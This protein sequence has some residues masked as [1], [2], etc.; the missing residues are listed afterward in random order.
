MTIEQMHWAIREGVQNMD[1]FTYDNY[2]PQQLDFLINQKIGVFVRQEYFKNVN[3]T[4]K[5]M[6]FTKESLHNLQT[7]IN[8]N[9]KAAPIL[10][11][12][13]YSFN[14]ISGNTALNPEFLFLIAVDAGTTLT[15]TTDWEYRHLRIVEPE[16]LR[17][18][19]DNPF[20]TT[21]NLSPVGVFKNNHL[22]VYVN[23]KFI[24]NSVNVTYI[25]KPA[26]VDSVSLVDC[27][28]PEH[29]HQII[30]DM[31]IQSILEK[32]ENPRYQQ[33][34]NENMLNK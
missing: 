28:L 3:M 33:N 7:L 4:G 30:C 8:T 26:T 31:V 24:V 20:R 16:I 22:K 11:N 34:V 12:N 32:T 19:L 1:S 27:D 5:G 17:Y 23:G 21:S 13:S 2:L 18:V 25:K 15:G 14:L 9:W 10:S 6:E 29:T